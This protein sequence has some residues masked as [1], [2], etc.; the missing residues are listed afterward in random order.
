MGFIGRAQS[1]PL[2]GTHEW[3]RLD[4]TTP[5]LPSYV[6]CCRVVLSALPDTSGT[7]LVR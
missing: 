5:E 1:Q 3:M 4:V 6:Y 7:R 2:T